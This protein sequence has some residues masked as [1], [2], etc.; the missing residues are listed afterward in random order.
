MRS[1]LPAAASLI[2]AALLATA[3]RA[4]AEESMP[5]P[6]PAPPP[7]PGLTLAAGKLEVAINVEINVGADAV[8]KPIS[9]APDL[10]Y[11]VTRDLT[12]MI[13]HGS[14]LTTGFRGAAGN[15]LCLTGTDKGCAHV[16]DHV[17]G[18]ALYSLVRGPLAVAANAGV[19]ALSFDA[20]FYSAKLGAK[21]RYK[22]GKLMVATAPSVLVAMTE[23]DTNPDTL[24]LPVVIGYSVTDPLWLGFGTGVK[25]PRSG[26]A[27]NWKLAVGGLAQYRIDPSMAVGASLIFGQIAGGA[28]ATGADYR[29]LQLWF[30]YSR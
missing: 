26:L 6:E 7:K 12:V 15:G 1:H 22:A 24:W 27:D 23:R 10:S 13:V 17:G 4:R 9:I 3:G 18:E 25:G 29:W 28:D 11:G 5:A 20:G 16:Y 14:F 30:S 21:L 2:A 19:H 8:A